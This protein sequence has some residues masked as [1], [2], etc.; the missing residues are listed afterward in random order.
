MNEA[1][2]TVLL[3]HVLLAFTI[4]HDNE[5]ERLMMMSPYRPFLVSMVMWSNF[6]RFISADGTTVKELSSA[7]GYTDR[8]HPSLPGMERWGYVKIERNPN[9]KRA[10]TPAEDSIVQPGLS[11]LKAQELWAG[12]PE[13]ILARWQE[14]FG[15]ET[16]DAISDRLRPLIND[17]G[18]GLPEYLP[19]LYSKDFRTQ[20]GDHPPVDS[21]R[22]NAFPVVLSW[23]L[24]AFTM[25]YERRS[26]LALPLIANI[27]RVI[28]EDGVGLSDIP[29]L[30]GIAK[31]AT[32][33]SLTYLQKND[34]ATVEH[35]PDGARGKWVRLT[36]KGRD[37]QLAHSSDLATTENAWGSRL[38]SDA[39]RNA[40]LALE[41]VVGHP[42][43]GECFAITAEGWRGKKPYLTQ[44]RAF[45]SRP[46]ESLPHH[47]MVL[48]RGGWPDGS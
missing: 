47:P 48:H 2:F 3:S 19:V 33:M 18:Q 5:W 40:R 10:K 13:V 14:R 16:V 38:G 8:P 42:Q 7:A 12:L 11:G 6:M 43:F 35:H 44:T 34:Y 21:T 32:A 9:A 25:E 23:P 22:Q 30:S 31:E 17:I 1:P 37:A 27:V 28:G 41:R 46:Q 36:S 24:I 29:R 20:I 4:E 26:E 39:L 15:S 45:I